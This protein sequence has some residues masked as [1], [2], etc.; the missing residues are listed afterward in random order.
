MTFPTDD[1]YSPQTK[2]NKPLPAPY[3]LKWRSHPLFIVFTVGMGMFVD[4]ILYGLIVPVVPFM[5]ED[6]IHVPPDQVQGYVSS[7]LAFY[8]GASVVCSLPFGW[9]ADR[10]GGRQLPF[11]LGLAALASATVLLAVGQS[12]AVLAVARALQGM[13]GAVV[14]V[15]GLALLL[16]TVG[17]EKLGTVIG[18]IYSFM[19]V[20]TLLAPV[21]GG[22]LY[23]HTG[24]TGVFG[25]AIVFVAIDFILRVLVIEPKVAIKYASSNPPTHYPPAQYGYDGTASEAASPTPSEQTLLLPSNPRPDPA[26]RL[27]STPG[28][29]TTRLPI[30]ACLPN[31]RLQA[32]FFIGLVQAILLGAFDSTIPTAAETLFGFDSLRAGLLFLSLGIGDLLLGPVFGWLIDKYGARWITVGGFAWLVPCL[33]SLRFVHAGGKHEVIVLCAILVL[34]GIGLA[35]IN[36]PSLVEAGTVVERYHRAN[37][38]LFGESGPYAQL[39]GMNSMIW[40][41]GLTVGPLV[42]GALKERV[43]Y[44]NMNAVLAGLCGVAV[45]VAWFFVGERDGKVEAEEQD[46]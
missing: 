21:L 7:L 9:L 45:L 29:W 33:A 5:L 18:T 46:A 14:W 41:G 4:M 8:A 34:C 22:V 20:G 13:S 1:R 43:G 30:L 11:L 39:Y 16:E 28:K 26:Y 6:R 40:C 10:Y 42:A 3:G 27:T 15:V 38:E 35:M 23:R 32:A 31:T 12:I 37:P 19:S 24:F 2:P 17:P 25:L 44:G 36:A